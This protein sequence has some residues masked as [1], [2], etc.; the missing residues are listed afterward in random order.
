MLTTLP[1]PTPPPFFFLHAWE[2]SDYLNQ[3]L[4]IANSLQPLWV[5]L[6]SDQ[7]SDTFMPLTLENALW[8]ADYLQNVDGCNTEQ[9]NVQCGMI[10]TI[11]RS[12][13]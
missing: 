11:K 2:L 7:N 5:N 10:K 3:S 9:V 1:S 13:F 12:R 4:L 6:I 8:N